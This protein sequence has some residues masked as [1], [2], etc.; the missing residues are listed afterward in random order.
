VPHIPDPGDAS[1]IRSRHQRRH[2]SR[3]SIECG[4]S[5]RPHHSTLERLIIA[6]AGAAHFVGV[7]PNVE[8][9]SEDAASL[10]ADFAVA[11]TG[12]NREEAYMLLSIIGE[13]RVGTSP[14]PVI[15]TQPI[16]LEEPLR[17]PVAGKP[18]INI[19]IRRTGAWARKS[20]L[21]LIR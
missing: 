2:P 21:S 8:E 1:G 6:Q 10:A 4:T 13:L 5:P 19:Q 20:K 11:R 16:V 18:Y 7:G 3:T 9:A 12:L 14:H 15:A 17:S